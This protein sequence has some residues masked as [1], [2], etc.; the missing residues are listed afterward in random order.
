LAEINYCCKAL[1]PAGHSCN[2]TCGD[3]NSLIAKDNIKNT[4]SGK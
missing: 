2:L 3:V 4:A 1:I